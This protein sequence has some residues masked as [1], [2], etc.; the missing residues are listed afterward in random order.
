MTY[1]CLGM[2]STALQ[3]LL[4]AQVRLL[5]LLA[6]FPLSTVRKGVQ[7]A[8]LVLDLRRQYSSPPRRTFQTLDRPSH[9]SLALPSDRLLEAAR[10]TL[11]PTSLVHWAHLRIILDLALSMIRAS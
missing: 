11:H 5:L 4:A 1:R 2:H 9:R 3:W 10:I 6:Q 8:V 7:A